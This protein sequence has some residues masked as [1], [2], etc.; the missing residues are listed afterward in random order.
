MDVCQTLRNIAVFRNI[1]QSAADKVCSA[2]ILYKYGK[3]EVIFREKEETASF[4]FVAKGIVYLSKL[5]HHQESRVIFL[6]GEGEMLNESLIDGHNA[7]A[8]AMTLTET[9]I[10]K[11]CVRDMREL[12]RQEPAIADAVMKSMAGKIRRLYR[13]MKNTN[14]SVHLEQQ[15]AAKLWKLSKDYGIQ[16]AYGRRIPFDLSITFL[17]DMVGSKRETVSRKVKKLAELGLIEMK[18]K[19]FIINDQEELLRFFHK[20]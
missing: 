7:S 10:I 12:M 1:S 8:T 18:G 5:N 19:T 13:Q 14:N 2:A 4:C 3:N 16:E 15:I 20:S 9:V 6:C 11:I 17:A